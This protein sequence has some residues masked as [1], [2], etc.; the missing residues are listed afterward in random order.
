MKIQTLWQPWAS[1]MAW[2]WITYDTRSWHTEYRGK[3]AIHAAKTSNHM[4]DRSIMR[5]CLALIAKAGLRKEGPIGV[6]P[7][8]EI[9][10]VA[11]LVDIVATDAMSRLEPLAPLERA[12]GDYSPMRWIWIYENVRPVVPFPYRCRPGLF[13]ELPKEVAAKLKY[14]KSDA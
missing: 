8:G 10:A 5:T 13:Q 1:A 14:A 7:R 4:S 2:G 9:L 3:V 11:E 12:F 6:F